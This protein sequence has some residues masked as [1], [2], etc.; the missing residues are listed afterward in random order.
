[1]R[2]VPVGK[3]VTKI[4]DRQMILHE[5]EAK[6]TGR[7]S[8][9]SVKLQNSKRAF[10]HNLT[11]VRWIADDIPLRTR[12]SY[13]DAGLHSTPLCTVPCPSSFALRL[14]SRTS[15]ISSVNYFESFVLRLI[16]DH[17]CTD[18]GLVGNTPLNQNLSRRIDF[19]IKSIHNVTESCLVIRCRTFVYPQL[20]EWCGYKRNRNI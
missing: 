12:H 10:N 20:D 15:F 4:N 1:M 19:K 11:D 18:K 7:I 2:A 5:K 6:V 8:K 13:S 17:S 14:S 9:Q 3:T 16:H